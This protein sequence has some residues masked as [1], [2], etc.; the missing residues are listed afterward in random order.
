MAEKEKTET[1]ALCKDV[2]PTNDLHYSRWF[3]PLFKRRP[4]HHECLQDLEDL[5]LEDRY[6]VTI[7]SMFI[8]AFI[9]LS[10]AY[11]VIWQKQT[12]GWVPVGEWLLYPSLIL[13]I[14]FLGA[15]VYIWWKGPY[16]LSH[17]H[18][19]R[20]HIKHSEEK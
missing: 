17:P 19:K 15:A 16:V 18:V 14:I 9:T 13:G 4:F 3:S 5:F 2:I 1:C 12:I 11:F 7:I 6:V 10:L 20:W 8:L